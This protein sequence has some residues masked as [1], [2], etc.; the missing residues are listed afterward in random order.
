MTPG[1]AK[2]AARLVDEILAR[3]LTISVHDSEEYVLRRTNNNAE[4]LAELGHTDE[5]GFAL[6]SKNDE[7]VG[8]FMLIF[9]NA[10]DGSELIADCSANDICAEICNATLT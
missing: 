1:E 10:A 5:N 9:G 4:I 6:F 2:V 8:Y 7:Y 3:N